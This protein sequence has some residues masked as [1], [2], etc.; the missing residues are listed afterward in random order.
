APP[1]SP[2]APRGETLVDSPPFRCLLLPSEPSDAAPIALI[3]FPTMDG[4]LGGQWD[5]F[6]DEA[7]AAPNARGAAGLI[8]DIR[9]NGGG[10]TDLGEALRARVTDRPYRMNSKLVWRRSEESDEKF[11]MTAKPMSRWLLIA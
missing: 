2:A 9:E 5:K 3:D 7:I 1:T 6:L 8:D 10:S 4:T 11:R